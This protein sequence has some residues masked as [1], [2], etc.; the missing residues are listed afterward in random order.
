[1]K[2][3]FDW[4]DLGGRKLKKTVG[5]NSFLF[6]PTNNFPKFRE[7]MS[8]FAFTLNC[9]IISLFYLFIFLLLVFFLSFYCVVLFFFVLYFFLLLLID[10]VSPSS[11]FSF[12]FPLASSV[13]GLTNSP[14]LDDLIKYTRLPC[15]DT[16]EH[17][18]TINK[19]IQCREQLPI[20]G[21]TIGASSKPIFMSPEVLQKRTKATIKAPMV[22]NHKT[23][24]IHTDQRQTRYI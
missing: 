19:S 20:S 1:M 16:D 12:F 14:S 23:I 13:M 6:K 8:D 24:Y 5:P 22:R 10:V 18:I 15:H 7:N 11:F 2:G 21:Q 3:V 17:R 9:S 4:N